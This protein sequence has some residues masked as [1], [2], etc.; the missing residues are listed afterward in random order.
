MT[1]VREAVWDL[2]RRHNVT[3]VFGNP[4]STELSMLDRFPPDLRYVLG[5]QEAVV[6]GM[7]DGHAQATGTIAM[8][9]VH[10]SAGLGNAMG[11]IVNAAANRTPMVVTAG[12]QV[13]AMMTLEALLTNVDATV[14]PRP[15]VKWAYEPPRA[16]DVPHALARAFHLAASP[17]CGPVFVSLPMDDLE[18]D[19][20]DATGSG[21]A[22]EAAAAVIDR[23]VA[24]RA[25]VPADELAALAR[26]IDA[27]ASPVLVLGGE[28][29]RSG[30][31]AAAIELADK[32]G[33][34][35]WAA[36]LESG[37]C[38]PQTHPRFQGFLQPAIGLLAQQLSG[39]DLIVVAGAP[40][41]R[42]YPYIP[43]PY[44]P[45]GAALAHITSDPDEASRAPVGDALVGD[46][47]HALTTLADLVKEAERTVPQRPGPHVLAET[48][49]GAGTGA[50][51]G[52]APE[53]VFATMARVLPEHTLWVNESPSNTL[54]F[55]DQVRLTA[56]GS[57][58]FCQGGGLGFGL[59]AAVGA[60]LGRPDRRVVAVMGDGSMQYAIPALWTAA[61]YDV[62]VTVVVL[63]NHEY[64]ILK[65]FG[66]L[67]NVS[68]IP[69]LDIDGIDIRAIATGYG[70]PAHLVSSPAELADLLGAETTGPR[71]LEIPISATTKDLIS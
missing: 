52:M 18:M 67:E 37:T 63:T 46:V 5:L 62:P 68:G 44:L 48:G 64:A 54:I 27:A 20:G 49:S 22:A 7:A 65:L 26:R 16:Q 56:P 1:T 40:V 71:L 3:S 23:R 51:Q 60:Q 50:G 58:L 39:H 9:N 30:A 4:G 69:G 43:G 15:A 24:A 55:Q 42:Y 32:A 45:P 6:V 17:P 41:F 29:D 61:A 2:V 8:V 36:P 21:S 11:A 57:F 38:F 31:F 59:P 13:R 33:L 35:V 19:L 53:R 10:T 70:V 47:G 34:P 66:R 14:L 28:V 25:T 12:Q